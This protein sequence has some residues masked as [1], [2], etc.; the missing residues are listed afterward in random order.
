MDKEKKNG[1]KTEITNIR[2]EGM[3]IIKKPQRH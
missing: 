1:E 2:N 3:D